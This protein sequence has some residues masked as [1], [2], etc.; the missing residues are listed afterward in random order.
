M[1][2]VPDGLRRREARVFARALTRRAAGA[3]TISLS[4]KAEVANL[5]YVFS[6]LPLFFLGGGLPSSILPESLRRMAEIEHLVDA[7]PEDLQLDLDLL[8]AFLEK[9]TE[10]RAGAC[11]HRESGSS[12]GRCEN[13]LHSNLPVFLT[14]RP[15]VFRPYS[16]DCDIQRTVSATIALRSALANAG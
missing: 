10:F 6:Q 12:K 3:R 9:E 5:I 8:E 14:F 4:P 1:P 11:Y 7:H 2:D 16:P 15:T 13:F